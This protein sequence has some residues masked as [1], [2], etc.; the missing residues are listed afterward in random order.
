MDAGA[1]SRLKSSVLKLA[2]VSVHA[3]SVASAMHNSVQHCGP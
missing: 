1:V 2:L 3:C